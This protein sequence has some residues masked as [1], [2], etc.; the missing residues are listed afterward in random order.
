MRKFLLGCAMLLGMSMQN[1]AF[2]ALRE[3]IQWKSTW[4]TAA[5]Q[6]DTKSYFSGPVTADLVLPSGGVA[7]SQG[8]ISVSD[9]NYALT[10]IANPNGATSYINLIRT[11]GVANGSITYTFSGGLLAGTTFDVFDLEGGSAVGFPASTVEFVA[12]N[13]T[14]VVNPNWKAEYFLPHPTTNLSISPDAGATPGTWWDAATSTLSANGGQQLGGNS[15]WLLT[16]TGDV[17]VTS[18]VLSYSLRASDGTSFGVISPVPEPTS[19]AIFGLAAGA[20]GFRSWR[21][22]K[23]S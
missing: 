18:V 22:R 13:G 15:L 6:S 12:Y 2:G 21:R 20:A 16:Y 23:S 11:A 8:N 10:G 5:T 3:H 19:M 4:G 7:A 9:S 17:P 14:S 1:A